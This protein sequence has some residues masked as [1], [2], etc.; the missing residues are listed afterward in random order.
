M[1][2]SLELDAG[3]LVCYDTSPTD[4]LLRSVR[5]HA[6]QAELEAALLVSAQ[7]KAQMLLNEVFDLP[8]DAEGKSAGEPIVTLPK[9][10]PRS[11]LPRQRPVPKPKPET[12][13]EKFAKEKGIEQ[14]KRGRMVWDEAHNDWRPR[15][16][17]GKA[18]DETKDWIVEHKEGDHYDSDED[19]FLARARAKK[20]R[21]L[22]NKLQQTRNKMEASRAAEASAPI[23]VGLPV[24]LSRN[25]LAGGRSKSGMGTAMSVLKTA[26]T[27]TASMGD[28]DERGADEAD[29]RR[30]GKRKRRAAVESSDD[31]DMM[32]RMA[33][34]VLRRTGGGESGELGLS[35]K[36]A[37]LDDADGDSDDEGSSRRKKAKRGQGKGGGK[38]NVLAMRGSKGQK[39]KARGRAKR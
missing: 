34:R 35:S 22:K 36:A 31:I 13:W 20:E 11:L 27:A 19:P 6:P 38:G 2:S 32:Q 4:G 28:F 16:G 26:Q 14:R 5:A 12:R 17:Y 39:K 37:G 1:A 15:W 33:D 29:L 21:V 9:R 18:N 24:D 3:R 30:K 23:P 8:R 25:A 7:G 10:L